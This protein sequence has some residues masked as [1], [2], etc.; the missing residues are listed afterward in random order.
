ME[1]ADEF[2]GYAKVGIA[3]GW[4]NSAAFQ[5]HQATERLYQCVL[6]TLTLYIPKLHDLR[7]LRVD[8]CLPHD[9]RLSN[10]WRDDDLFGAR[11]FK[12]LRAAYVDARY[13]IDYKITRQELE[14]LVARVEDLRGVVDEICRAH[15]ARPFDP[16]A[17]YRLRGFRPNER[18]N[19][20]G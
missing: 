6:L 10:V 3:Q 11:C 5:L 16:N 7:A 18:W 9:S 1:K 15:L 4:N 2:L 20:Q 13:E 19:E 12:L 8:W 14:W 17:P